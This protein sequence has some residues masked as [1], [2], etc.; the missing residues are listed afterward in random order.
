MMV[1]FNVY[2][3]Y[4]DGFI[5]FEYNWHPDGFIQCTILQ[6]TVL[7]INS[8]E[9]ATP[10]DKKLLSTI[11]YIPLDGMLISQQSDIFR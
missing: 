4:P 5:Q 10:A 7:K 11:R 8:R 9:G 2:T 6:K 1:L 3:G